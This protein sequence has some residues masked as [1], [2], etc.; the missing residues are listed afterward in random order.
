MNRN[1]V[2]GEYFRFANML[3]MA[4]TSHI[5]S[6]V[7]AIFLSDHSYIIMHVKFSLDFLYIDVRGILEIRYS[8]LSVIFLN[9]Y[10]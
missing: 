4:R 6:F 5:G 8:F 2:K 10:Q 3:W 9:F 1:V 7:V